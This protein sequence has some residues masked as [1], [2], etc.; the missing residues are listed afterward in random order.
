V[1]FLSAI[2]R[3]C[4]SALGTW[5]RAWKKGRVAVM[6]HVLGVLVSMGCPASTA[7]PHDCY[8]YARCAHVTKST[9]G[10]CPTLAL[11]TLRSS[12]FC[13]RTITPQH[14]CADGRA[15]MQKVWVR[16]TTIGP[17]RAGNQWR[18]CGVRTFVLSRT[19]VQP[20]GF[21]TVIQDYQRPE[22]SHRPCISLSIVATV[23]K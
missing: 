3:L 20:C 9:F 18:C 7:T 14:D 4:L 1:K 21:A 19:C 16:I 2:S 23:R 5:A 11:R 17:H 10:R 6:F 8:T 15:R 13:S 22:R 12:T